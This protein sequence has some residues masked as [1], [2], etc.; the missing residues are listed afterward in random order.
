MIRNVTI[1]TLRSRPE[2]KEDPKEFRIPILSRGVHYHHR[3][4]EVSGC[5]RFISRGSR[6]PSRSVLLAP[7]SLCFS[8]RHN[9]RAWRFVPVTPAEW[10]QLHKDSWPCPEKKRKRER[11]VSAR[12]E[13]EIA[14]PGGELWR[15]SEKDRAHQKKTQ[16]TEQKRERERVSER[17][18]REREEDWPV[19]I[20]WREPPSEWG[21]PMNAETERKSSQSVPETA[22]ALFKNLPPRGAKR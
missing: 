20:G 17:E 15:T 19:R 7:R 18:G 3:H 9:A 22:M 8:S 14:R 5:Y 2:D 13:R 11:E 6:G 1:S 16:E 10:C 12:P 21:H 4:H